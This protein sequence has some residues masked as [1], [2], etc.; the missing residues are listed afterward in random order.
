M[1]NKNCL[2]IAGPTAVG[3]TPLAIGLAEHF[4]TQIISADSRQCYKELNIGVANPSSTA[5][6][7]VKHYFIDSHSI[8]EDVNAKIFE[9]YALKAVD[10]IFLKNDIAVMVGGTGLY[11]KAFCDGIDE[12]P[13]V[14]NNIK[15]K[16][17]SNFQTS[18]IEWLQNE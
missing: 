4:N 13:V 18:G 3:K 15:K 11:I 12:I 17:I 5:L 16:I 8:H 9:T 7:K 10:T 1:T 2:V 14:D 6:G